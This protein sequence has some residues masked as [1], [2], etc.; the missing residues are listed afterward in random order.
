[1]Q[2][3][4]L[5]LDS[6]LKHRT[7]GSFV[8]VMMPIEKDGMEQEIDHLKEFSEEVIYLLREYLPGV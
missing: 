8:R 7:D 6:V 1:M 2:K 3:I 5:V 4:Y